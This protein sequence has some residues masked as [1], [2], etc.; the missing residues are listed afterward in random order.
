MKE[1]VFVLLGIVA[2]SLLWVLYISFFAEDA[3]S[4]GERVKAWL[5]AKLKLPWRR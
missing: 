3:K 1:F 5:R 4:M 2:A